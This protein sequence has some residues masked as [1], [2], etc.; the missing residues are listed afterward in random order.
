MAGA[1]TQSDLFPGEGAPPGVS[2]INERCQLRTQD[3]HRVVLVS[4]IVLAQYAIGDAVAEA[5]AMV[6]LVDQGWADQKQVARAFDCAT[7]TVRRDQRRFEEGGLAAL[8]RRA[9][10][11]RGRPRLRSHRSRLVS[12]LKAAGHS[13]RE[14]ARRIGVSEVAVRKLLRR[15]GW[16]PAKPAQGRLPLGVPGANP[17]LSASGAPP[18]ATAPEMAPPGA[19]PNLSAFAAA[20]TAP[21]PAKQSPSADPNLSASAA[22]AADDVPFTLDTDPANRSFD[23]L[24]AF[25]GLLDDAA[26]LFRA[27]VRVPRA[28]V[29]LALPA[30]I[31]SGVFDVARDIYASI[32]PAFYGLRTTLVTVLLMALLRIKRP[33][34]LKE[35][36]P[37]DLGRLLGLDRAPEVKTLRRKLTRL[38]ELGQAA[39]FG[40]ALAQRRVA[41]RGCAVGFLYVDGHVR[42][43]HGK[44]T[45]PKTH[46]AQMRRA[47]P[48]T[49]DYWVNDAVGDP[50][51]VVTA[52]ANAGMVKMLPLVLGEVRI[53]LPGRRITI[54][55]DRGGWSPKL[56]AVV[57]ADGFDILTYRKGSFPRVPKR[58]F[59]IRRSVIEG[60]ERRYTLAEQRVRFLRGK[61][62]L[63]QI[64]L[65]SDDGKHQ[66]PILTS[67][68]DISLVEVAFRMFERWRQENFF[69]YLREEYALDALVD[70][71]VEPDDPNRDVPN[72]ARK[73]IDEKLAEAREA[74]ARVRAKYGV[75]A[76]TNPEAVRR[77]MRGF[78]NA[79]A[80][81]GDDIGAAM[82]CVRKLEQRRAKMPQ[83][84]PVGQV[85]EGV[86]IK[87]ATERKLLTNHF[88]MVAYQAES[89]LFRLVTPHYKRAEREGR[90]L[91]QSALNGSASID[92]TDTELR[93]TLAPLSS[94]H[95]T[96]AIVALCDEMNHRAVVFP[97]TKLRLRYAV[98][99]APAAP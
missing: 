41:L 10:Y 56:F 75:A 34:A 21:T 57:I 35:H 87:L 71:R 8:G 77:T 91:I 31:D 81:I 59:Q 67:R 7:R 19:N 50:L 98:E 76:F 93:V 45:L 68:M 15:L 44:H 53:L 92:V 82:H 30:L 61:L 86:V 99:A 16:A 60:R 2:V 5:N 17:N 18:P 25:L 26:P 70:Y 32:G 64:T 74:L 51:F 9:G 40:R 90:T 13:N 73:V 55:F 39:S 46:V 1:K 54:V 48:A 49:S 78:K 66:T 72:P 12:R 36:L 52:E 65:L 89:D 88:K 69:K 62:Y 58:S 27:G 63:R 85:V 14:I 33:E 23:R 94:A 97:G 95:R 47:M 20:P 42:V 38:A 96:R 6:S 84:V 24:L 11:P 37:E 22:A 4:S 83:R 43:Y 80:H 29:L 79:H 28:G 3:G